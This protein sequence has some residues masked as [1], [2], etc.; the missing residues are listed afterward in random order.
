MPLP[1][2][3]LKKVGLFVIVLLSC[4]TNSHS[5]GRVVINEFMAWSG[6]SIT[7]EFIELMNFGPGP[8]DIS[9]YIVTNGQYAVTI[10]PGTILKP[11]QYY[12]LAGQDQIRVDCKDPSTTRKVDLN[13][14]TCN[15]TNKPVPTT[16]NG[17]LRDGGNANEKVVLLDSRLQVVD[18]VSR[19]A[20]FSASD[21]IISKSNG[22][23]TSYTFDLDHMNI[24]Y[25][26]IENSTGIDNSFARRVDG[27]CG[28]V[29]TTAISPG[30]ANKTG[31]SSSVSYNL[32]TV[33][34]SEC[35]SSTGYISI[36]VN[37]TNVASLFPMNY[38]LGF[39]GD[40]NG[41]FNEIDT[42][43]Y[44]VDSTSPS[45]DINN[46]NYGRYSMTVGSALGCNLQTFNFFIFDCNGTV[47][48]LK[49]ISFRFINSENDYNV[50][51]YE[52]AGNEQL[53]AIFI[54]GRS[55]GGAF[56]T[57]N[58][59]QPG[60][61]YDGRRIRFKIPI[62]TFANY[63]LRAVD[64]N[65]RVS[66]SQVVKVQ[67]ARSFQNRIWPN[68]SSN[69]AYIYLAAARPQTVV[70]EMINAS[71]RTVAKG[72]IKVIA[73]INTFPLPVRTLSAGVYQVSAFMK[74]DNTRHLFRFVKQ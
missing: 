61:P 50:F 67:S 44:G 14:T 15:C 9:C 20:A 40:K 21:L 32:S 72:E 47:L 10:P 58:A 27:D 34:S 28:W 54:E 16:V 33:S 2:T 56:Q 19:Y 39:D 59:L 73:G 57:I 71:G 8:M 38:T 62:G 45:I 63:R 5:Q 35:N 36:Q 49:F 31:S 68:P 48:P 25:E 51:D 30:A 66:Y 74:D 7:S 60:V 69:S 26:S 6:C 4:T 42:Y 3:I 41:V 24:R 17:F 18:A 53:K 64:I 65:N 1:T 29:K 11:G 23:C 55:T 46:L 22:S 52:L 43:S 37:A 13:W 70:Y 12:L